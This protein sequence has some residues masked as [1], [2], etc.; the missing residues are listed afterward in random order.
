MELRQ[1]IRI[2]WKWLWMIALATVI[3]GLASFIASNAAVPLYV[4]RTTIMIGRSIQNPDPNSADLWTG[5]Q[6]ALTYIQ[7]VKREPIMKAALESIGLQIPWQSIANQVNATAIAQT[8]LVEITVVDSNPFRAKS[9][10][11]AVANQLVLQS[12]ASKSGLTMEQTVF[13]ENQINDLQNKITSAY[14]DIEKLRLQRDAATSSRQIQ[15]LSNQISIME[16]KITDWQKTYSQLILS[17]KGGDANALSIVEEASVPTTPFSPNIPMNVATAAFIG[18]I[19]SIGGAFLIEFLDDTI[20]S[21]EDIERITP[22]PILGTITMIEGD[23]YQDKLIS[24]IQP[25]S[26]ISEAFR[27]LRTNMRFSAIDKPLRSVMLTSPGPGEGKS[28]TLANLAVATAQAGLKV[29]IVDTDLR[30]PVQH[31][32]FN[33]PNRHGLTDAILHPALGVD[34]FLQNT[35]IENIRILTTGPLPPN[36]SELLASERLQEVIVA[37]MHSA[38]FVFFDSPPSLIL[39]DA[40]ILATRVDGVILVS[41]Y[42]STHL[43]E[44]KNSVVDLQRG[45]ANLIGLV[46]NRL[47]VKGNRYYYHYYYSNGERKKGKRSLTKKLFQK[48]ETITEDKNTA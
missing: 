19:L 12:P 47:P 24:L 3:A 15:D 31:R 43:K 38:D 44:V 4:T 22:L 36:P 30:R 16:N 28:V 17:I 6:L 34:E 27:V 7:L 9:I 46:I 26:P 42:G 14:I 29:I 39:A 18:F 2:V 40:A 5:Q 41:D 25:R 33:L 21:P 11:D 23:D 8:Q 1:I 10:A 20:R 13:A 37:L 45:H 32:L 48:K 35:G